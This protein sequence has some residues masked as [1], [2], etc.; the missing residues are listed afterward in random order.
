MVRSAGRPH[1]LPSHVQ[2]GDGERVVLDEPPPRLDDAAHQLGKDLVGLREVADPHL[3]QRAHVAIERRLPKLLGIHL[4]E[5]LVAL[6]R[7]T[8]AACLVEGLA[9]GPR[10]PR[11]NR[12][13]SFPNR[14]CQPFPVSSAR[15]SSLWAIT[16]AI[17]LAASADCTRR[18]SKAPAIAACSTTG[19]E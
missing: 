10:P 12:K 5:A 15:V 4:A 6:Q 16:P 9:P 2:V 7:D 13:P 8:L 18:A 11:R 1:P 3:Q 19:R 14:P 17:L